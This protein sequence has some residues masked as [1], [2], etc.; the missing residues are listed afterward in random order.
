MKFIRHIVLIS[1]LFLAASVYAGQVNIKL[2]QMDSYQQ[3]L[4]DYKDQPLVLILWS[5]TCSACLAEME[6]IQRFTSKILN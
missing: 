2:F 6:L 3:I 1:S 4:S 5:I